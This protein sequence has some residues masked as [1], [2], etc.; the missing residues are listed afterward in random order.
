MKSMAD[1][2]DRVSADL[3]KSDIF[4]SSLLG[5]PPDF[6]VLTFASPLLLLY[7]G[8]TRRS[9]RYDEKTH[10]LSISEH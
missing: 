2:T 9:K 8:A 3:T 10:A 6:G 5:L 4:K 7:D 1:A